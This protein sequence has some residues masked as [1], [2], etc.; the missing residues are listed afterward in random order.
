MDKS[1][2][3]YWGCGNPEAKRPN[4]GDCGQIVDSFPQEKGWL[5]TGLS[6]GI[7]DFL[8]YFRNLVVDI[9]AFSHLLTDLL[10]RVHH[11][12]VVAIAKI[13]TDFRERQVC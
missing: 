12:G 6:A 3:N 13:H 10:G 9:A 11:S 5:S 8:N 2:E 4:R 7:L 1:G